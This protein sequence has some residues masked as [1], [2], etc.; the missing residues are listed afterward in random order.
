MWTQW[1]SFVMELSSSTLHNTSRAPIPTSVITKLRSYTEYD[2][3]WSCY[4][5]CGSVCYAEAATTISSY[6][7]VTTDLTHIYGSQAY[8]VG[9][10]VPHNTCEISPNIC[11]SIRSLLGG[12]TTSTEKS[13]RHGYSQQSSFSEGEPCATTDTYCQIRGYDDATLFYW[14]ISATMSRDM[15]TEFPSL[16]LLDM[17]SQQALTLP[18]LPGQGMPWVQLAVL[19]NE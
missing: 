18:K 4:S 1:V 7:V 17:T 12:R 3:T 9:I 19:S 6:L 15:C 10:E 2:V 13:Q 16:D 14:P 5:T 11:R 8:P